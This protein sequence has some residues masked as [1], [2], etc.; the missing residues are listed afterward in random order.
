MRDIYENAAG[1][2][3]LDAD[4]QSL[5]REATTT[6][7][8]SR[9][10]ISGWSGRLWT[11]QEGALT[12]DYFLVGDQCVFNLF[13]IRVQLHS[14]RHDRLS[15]TLARAL[16]TRAYRRLLM[17]PLL[18]SRSPEYAYR[19]SL[20]EVRTCPQRIDVLEV[21]VKNIVLDSYFE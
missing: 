17:I 18:M 7:I 1:V 13:D 6:E 2:F 21:Y 16:R 10:L 15:L 14:L 4:L 12:D 9:V 11:Y 8:L 19:L 5:T 20:A 3:V